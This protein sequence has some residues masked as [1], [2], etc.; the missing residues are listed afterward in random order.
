MKNAFAVAGLALAVTTGSGLA[1]AQYEYE[2]EGVRSGTRGDPE[3]RLERMR[4]H[5]SLT[6]E[7]VEQMRSIRESDATRAEKREQM[8]A[9]LTEEQRNI[10]REHRPE[11]GGRRGRRRETDSGA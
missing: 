3:Q 7:Q 11:H 2:G 10:I 4:E 1:L 5:L 8:R 6:D 9:V